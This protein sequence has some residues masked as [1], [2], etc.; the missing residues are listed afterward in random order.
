MRTTYRHSG[1]QVGTFGQLI[2][3]YSSE[4]FDSPTRSTVPSLAFWLDT[5]NRVRDLCK[6]ISTNTPESCIME[7]EYQVPTEQGKGKPSH[8]DLMISWDDTC[9]GIEAKYTEP[10]YE[11][12]NKWLIEGK[13]RQNREA[14]LSG[15][16]NMISRVT[17][18]GMSILSVGDV[19]YQMIHRI[20]S[21]CSRYES[22]KNVIYQ[23][24]SPSAETLNYYHT[25]L[26]RIRAIMGP[27]QSLKLFL[28][29]I[30]I[31]P[32][33]KYAQMINEWQRNRLLKYQVEVIGGLLEGNL[34]TFREGRFEKIE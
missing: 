12:V 29:V 23:V 33:D 32:S 19:T 18:K 21:T 28:W 9:V 11:T 14:V 26:N 7:F 15:W 2:N 17:E 6:K 24:F 30:D 20:A 5:D 25:H 1:K 22:Q 4:E 27:T 31:V 8:T 34:M 13:D 10:P 3:R 16:C